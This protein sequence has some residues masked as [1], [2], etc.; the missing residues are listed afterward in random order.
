MIRWARSSR[1]LPSLQRV[2]RQPRTAFHVP[3]RLIP[4]YWLH[5]ISR[6][7]K[8]ARWQKPS[9]RPT[10]PSLS[11][12]TWLHGRAVISH[13]RRGWHLWNQPKSLR[14]SPI[15]SPHGTAW[16]DDPD[17]CSFGVSR[18]RINP[19]RF[20][21]HRATRYDRRQG[22]AQVMWSHR[23]SVMAHD[24]ATFKLRDR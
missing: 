10:L 22:W 23:P 6:R 14:N 5:R 15:P 2:C 8:K 11:S 3:P 21:N 18:H 13:L 17:Q 4:S 1:R 24:A 20:V 16:S 9:I 7:L 19:G 12:S